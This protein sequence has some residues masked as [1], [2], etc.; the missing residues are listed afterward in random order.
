MSLK[1]VRRIDIEKWISF[2]YVSV[3]KTYKKETKSSPLVSLNKLFLKTP[4][5]ID[6]E[7]DTIAIKIKRLGYFLEEETAQNFIDDVA[8][9][10]EEISGRSIRRQSYNLVEVDGLYEINDVVLTCDYEIPEFLEEV[11]L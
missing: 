5:S 11:Q 8:K 2:S 6:I 7:I 1:R 3:F 10:I 4:Q 9:T